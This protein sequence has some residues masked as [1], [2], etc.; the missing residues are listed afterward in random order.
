MAEMG[1]KSISV[2]YE[3]ESAERMRVMSEVERMRE[4]KTH[5]RE[6]DGDSAICTEICKR[7]ERQHHAH[8]R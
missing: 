6:K 7:K 5:S 2:R 3:E 1:V 8:L 4:R